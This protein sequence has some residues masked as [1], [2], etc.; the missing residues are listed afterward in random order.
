MG[1][2][3]RA[4]KWLRKKSS[5]DLRNALERQSSARLRLPD[6]RPRLEVLED[7]TVLTVTAVV[8]GANVTFISPLVTDNVYLQTSGSQVQW[9]TDDSNW[10]TLSKLTLAGP[11]MAND[12]TFQLSG[13]V[14]LENFTGA[15][16]DLTF[17][18]TGAAAA[19]F[20]GPGDLFTATFIP[21]G[22]A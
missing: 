8:S 21:M 11:G 17:G 15:G 12:F 18:G 1:A 9:S 10:T 7:R 20:I 6:W 22:A 4:R 14:H 5:R 3:S 16:G 13:D 19:G 2:V